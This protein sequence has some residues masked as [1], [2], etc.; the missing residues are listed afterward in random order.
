MATP[1]AIEHSP[2]RSDRPA[3][4]RGA[5]LKLLPL[6]ALLCVSSAALAED[7]AEPSGFRMDEY[8][9]PVPATLKGAEV[10]DT[11]R[12]EKIWR[13][14]AAVFFDVMPRAPK[15]TNLPEGTIWKDKVR[16]DIPGSTWL[17]NVGY[18]AISPET[19]RYFRDGLAARTAGDMSKP[20][21]FYCMTDCWMSWNAAKRALGWGYKSVLWYPPGSDG[22]ERAGLPLEENSPYIV[23]K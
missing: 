4:H 14:K 10:I 23:E 6:F 2:A 11:A 19:E 8:R 20:V 7:V 17:A 13:D 1:K 15:P 5:V 12:A 3:R 22:W 18:G 9:A 21:V 16:T